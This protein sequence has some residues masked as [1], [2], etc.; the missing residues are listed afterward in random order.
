MDHIVQRLLKL[1]FLSPSLKIKTEE[2]SYLTKPELE[3]LITINSNR[4]QMTVHIFKQL[5]RRPPSLQNTNPCRENEKMQN[6]LV[7]DTVQ[8]VS[9]AYTKS[10]II[11]NKIIAV[12]TFTG[13][14]MAN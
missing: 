8:R 3:N 9:N 2:N 7:Y 11:K 10:I 12:N 14:K 13:M 5:K 1:I 4:F 6:R